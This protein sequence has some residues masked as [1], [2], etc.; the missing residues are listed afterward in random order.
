MD[1]LGLAST[2]Y[3]DGRCPVRRFGKGVIMTNENYIIRRPEGRTPLGVLRIHMHVFGCVHACVMVVFKRGRDNQGGAL[4]SAIATGW[5]GLDEK[6]VREFPLSRNETFCGP[7]HFQKR[8]NGGV[9]GGQMVPFVELLGDNDAM[10]RRRGEIL[11]DTQGTTHWA[12]RREIPCSPSLRNINGLLLGKL[13]TEWAAPSLS[14]FPL[15]CPEG[16]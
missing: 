7:G 16:S 6:I 8:G 15:S 4:T 9:F 10:W 13:P 14:L 12:R 5:R 11:R 1:E 3:P 2:P